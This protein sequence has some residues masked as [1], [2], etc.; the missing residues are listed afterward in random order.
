METYAYEYATKNG[1]KV[2]KYLDSNG[3]EIKGV[4]HVKDLFDMM[5]GTSAG[6]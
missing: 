6:S 4:I 2:P 1:Y 5:A 3:A